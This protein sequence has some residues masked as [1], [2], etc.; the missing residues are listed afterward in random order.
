MYNEF[1]TQVDMRVF[2]QL[3]NDSA[4]SRSLKQVADTEHTLDYPTYIN[5]VVLFSRQ[6]FPISLMLY[7]S[8]LSILAE[9]L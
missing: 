4:L 6:H 3:R 5:T 1:D 9:S 8:A 2:H 7:L